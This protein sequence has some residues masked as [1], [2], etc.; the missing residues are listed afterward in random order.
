[1]AA[2]A[3]VIDG[4]LV[5]AEGVTEIAA[6]A[7]KGRV[8][9]KE[10]VLPDSVVKVGDNAFYRC[11]G[12]VALHLPDTLR[13]IGHGAFQQCTGLATL[14][15]PNTLQSIGDKAFLRCTRVPRGPDPQ[16]HRVRSAWRP[17]DG[18][19]SEQGPS[20]WSPGAACSRWCAVGGVWGP[21]A[22]VAHRP[23]SRADDRRVI[24]A[25]RRE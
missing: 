6:G 13:S 3:D 20:Y 12:I 11:T 25:P 22:D 4:R 9:I 2:E 15:L 1:M 21:R 24:I 17:P 7:Y 8:D 16:I 10:V 23:V 18:H 14:H 5:V 19:R